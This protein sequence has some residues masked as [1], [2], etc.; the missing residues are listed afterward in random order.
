LSSADQISTRSSLPLFVACLGHDE[1]SRELIGILGDIA[2]VMEGKL[3]FGIIQK[4][5]MR[6]FMKRYK[7][8]GT[9]SFVFFVQGQEM[10]RLLG[11]VDKEQI[12]AFIGIYITVSTPGD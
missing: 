9:P 12:E 8:E 10:D 11:R 7:I 4:G 3:R 2:I 5:F 1:D 6:D